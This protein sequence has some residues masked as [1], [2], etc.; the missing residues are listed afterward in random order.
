MVSLS[1]HE[2]AHR[3]RQSAACSNLDIG[4]ESESMK[5]LS[6]EMARYEELRSVVES[7]HARKW[8][9]IHA[10]DFIGAFDTLDNVANE[11]IR[12]YGRGPYLIRKAGR[13]AE[14]MSRRPFFPRTAR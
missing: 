4:I 9:V 7:H 3:F 13:R 8:I 1:N 11:A 10:R 5:A 14:L 6:V 12:L 2:A